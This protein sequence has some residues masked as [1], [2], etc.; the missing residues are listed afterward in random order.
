MMKACHGLGRN[1]WL[2]LSLSNL[3]IGNSLFTKE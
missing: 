3:Q 1:D 2:A